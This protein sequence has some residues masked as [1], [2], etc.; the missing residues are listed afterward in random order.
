M[1]K[2]FFP[3]LILSVLLAACGAPATASNA[4]AMPTD[5]AAPIPAGTP[6]ESRTLTVMT[7]DSFAASQGVVQEFELAN[8]VK[9]NFVKSGDA[10]AAL[11]KAILAKDAPLADVF[12]GVDNTFLSAPWLPISSSRTPR[13]CWPTSLPSSSLT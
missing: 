4:P 1:K 9:V 7:H 6:S 13:R 3:L 5:T 2:L 10:G 11:D 12:Y 8:N